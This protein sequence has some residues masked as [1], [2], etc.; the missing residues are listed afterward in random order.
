MA[1]F[2]HTHTFS[3]ITSKLCCISSSETARAA[4]PAACEMELA[5]DVI[6]PWIVVAAWQKGSAGM[7]TNGR[8][9]PTSAYYHVLGVL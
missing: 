2:T 3:R 7:E 9:L 1:I 6:C 4:S 5:H 8:L